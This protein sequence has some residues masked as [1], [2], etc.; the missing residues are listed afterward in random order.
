MQLK[1]ATTKDVDTYL[2]LENG[3]SDSRLYSRAEDK[4]E[5]LEELRKTVVYFIQQEGQAVGLIAYEMKAV[6][7]AYLSGI[8]IDPKYQGRGLAKEAMGKILEELKDVELIDV[9]VHPEN[10][11]SLKLCQSFGF[12]ITDRYENYFGDGEPRVKLVLTK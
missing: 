11:K 6:N 2:A 9:V 7:H 8:I 10:V 12:K 3:V 1:R 5:A 4:E